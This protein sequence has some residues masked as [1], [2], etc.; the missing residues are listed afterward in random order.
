[1]KVPDI[2]AGSRPADGACIVHHETDELLVQQHTVSDGQTTSI[3]E[4]AKYV[5]N[6]S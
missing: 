2:A 3:E 6:L 4:R 1:L 5:Q